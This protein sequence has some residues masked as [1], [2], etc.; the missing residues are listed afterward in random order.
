MNLANLTLLRDTLNALPPTIYFD[1]HAA[2]Q[3]H[4]CGTAACVAGVCYT[5]QYPSQD[6]QWVSW[7]HV[8]NRALD[9]LDLPQNEKN[10]GIGHPLFDFDLAPPSCTPQQAAI[11]V[12]RV[13]EGL[14]PWN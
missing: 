12:T 13:M 4:P 11:A 2:H 5:I 14:S 9:W 3:K 10:W 1:M 6:G 7:G 8:R